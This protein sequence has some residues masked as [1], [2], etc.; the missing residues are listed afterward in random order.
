[1]ISFECLVPIP[2][3]DESD[4]SEWLRS[5]VDG[6]NRELGPVAIIVGADEWLLDYNKRFLNHDFYTDIITFDYC[7]G[8]HLSGDL[9]ISWDRV[10]ENAEDLN[11]SRETELLRVMVHGLLHL[12]GYKDESPSEKEM[13]RNKEDYYLK[14]L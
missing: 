2:Q 9:L 13:M 14:L 8:N 10:S 3:L 1:M 11:V 7:K 4:T 5:V 6:E 12:C